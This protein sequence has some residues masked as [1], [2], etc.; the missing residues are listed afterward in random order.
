[1]PNNNKLNYKPKL[2]E[3]WA[4]K[5]LEVLKSTQIKQKYKSPYFLIFLAFIIGFVF[6]IPLVIIDTTYESNLIMFSDLW[7]EKWIYIGIASVLSSIVEMYLIFRLSIY[8]VYNLTLQ[9]GYDFDELRDSYV[10]GYDSLLSRLVIGMDEPKIELDGIK[11]HKNENKYK[12]IIKKILYRVRITLTNAIS[13]IL[14]R[15]VF[16]Q[17]GI[18]VQIEWVSAVVIGFW[19]AIAVYLVYKETKK[20]LNNM[21]KIDV[22]IK[23]L[24]HTTQEDIKIYYQMMGNLFVIAEHNIHALQYLYYEMKKIYPLD[25]KNLDSYDFLI[26][27]IAKI[28]TNNVYKYSKFYQFCVYISNI[29]NK[30]TKVLSKNLFER[31]N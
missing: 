30:K 22:F 6:S 4:H 11:A 18:R 2:L 21:K 7:I 26:A 20:L 23:N 9:Y 5:K 10:L 25:T 27:S 31:K 14:I 8:L 12:K 29:E 1:M 24:E 13:K 3:N 16:I 17:N 15:R 19:N 28:D